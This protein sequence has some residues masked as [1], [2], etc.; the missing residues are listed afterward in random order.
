MK[1]IRQTSSIG[2]VTA[3][4]TVSDGLSDSA[5]KIPPI[6]IPGARRHI[7]S[8][9]LIKFCICVTS[10]VSRV[11]SD[12]VLNRSMLENENCCTLRYTSARKSAAKFT[13]A[14]A[15]KYAPPTPPTIIISADRIIPTVTAM[16]N[17]DAPPAAR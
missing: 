6:S 15:P 1:N 17:G 16:I 5:I 12:P 10:L 7:R 9:I 4:T 13:D 11:T 3:S 8:S 2:T 14:F